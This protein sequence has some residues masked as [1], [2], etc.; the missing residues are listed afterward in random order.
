MIVVT[1]SGIASKISH[2]HENPAAAFHWPGYPE[3]CGRIET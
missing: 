2:D 1:F 3:R